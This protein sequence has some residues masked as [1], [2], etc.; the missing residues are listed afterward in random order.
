M[1]TLTG[2]V[3]VASI[4]LTLVDP[5][6]GLTWPDATL[7]SYLNRAERNACMLRPDLYM[8]RQAIPLV[9]GTLQSL[10]ANGTA[11]VRLDENVV[12]GKR[13]RL[14]DSALL[15]ALL[16]TWPAAAREAVVQEYC[17]DAKDRRRFHVLPPNDG[18]GSVIAHYAAVPPA[19]ASL[20]LTINL[21]D[22]YETVLLHFMLAE[23]YMADT[24][25]RD[26]AK[27]QALRANFEKGL[28]INAQSSAVLAP[29]YGATPGAA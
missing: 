2:T 28:G 21:D 5:S 25:K 11:L 7:L 20:A 12:G 1:G 23:A 17:A 4:R 26:A 6:P 13:C 19:L 9:E 3:I 16:Q 14:V 24:D 15:D 29:K 10:P 27:A 18:T 22:T 8:R